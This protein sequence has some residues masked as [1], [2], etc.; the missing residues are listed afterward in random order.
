MEGR[1]TMKKSN[2][3]IMSIL[4]LSILM[5]IFYG[6]IENTNV[7]G[8]PYYGLVTFNGTVTVKGTTTGAEGVKVQLRE[9]GAVKTHDYTD[10]DGNYELSWTTVQYKFYAIGLE[11]IGCFWQSNFVSPSSST[12]T[13]DMTLEGRVALFM[14]ASD[15]GNQSMIEDEYGNYL[16]NNLYFGD[17]LYHENPYDWKDSIEDLDDIET[18]ESLVFIHILGHGCP[19]NGSDW[20]YGGD[21]QIAISYPIVYNFLYSSDFADEIENLESENIIVIVDSCSSGDFVYEYQLKDPRNAEDVFMMASTQYNYTYNSSYEHHAAQ[22]FGDSFEYFDINKD[23]NGAYG[24]AFTHYF[25]EGLA[26]GKTDYEAFSY[27]YEATYNYSNTYFYYEPGDF[28][29]QQNAEYEDQLG[30]TWF[31]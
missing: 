23:F 11:M 29:L 13:K 1:K 9:D 18:S 19:Y 7:A 16:K 4:V 6:N 5:P 10:S 30:T 31:G 24:A 28:Y 12:H 22:W 21:S 17:V 3:I 26:D 8:A 25:F 14:W 20:D 15:V 27:S 2:K